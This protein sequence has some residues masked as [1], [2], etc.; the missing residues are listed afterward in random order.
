MRNATEKGVLVYIASQAWLLLIVPML[1]VFYVAA[2]P[3]EPL[4]YLAG[5]LILMQYIGL[6]QL[7]YVI[8][9]IW[10]FLRRGELETV[11]GILMCAS[12]VLLLNATCDGIVFHDTITAWFHHSR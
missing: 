8:P 5:L 6:A 11:K 4:G 7:L 10:F 12:M 2:Y 9:T 1:S 3:K